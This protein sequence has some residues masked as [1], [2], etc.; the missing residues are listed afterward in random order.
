MTIAK[1]KILI[2]DD[3]EALLDMYKEKLVFEGYEVHTA[4]DGEKGVA[5]AIEVLPDVILLDLIMPVMNGF[6]ALKA[7]K[8]DPQ[9]KDIPV[10]L[11]TNI[12]EAASG[13]KDKELGAAGY[14]FKAETEPRK[15]AAVMKEVKKIKR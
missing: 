9:T 15:L 14:L 6:D 13:G 1:L 5:K 2:V 7:L 3:E 4:M 12:P 8:A 10:Y 11:L